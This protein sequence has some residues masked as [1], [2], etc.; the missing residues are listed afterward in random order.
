MED[1]VLGLNIVYEIQYTSNREALCVFSRLK[2]SSPKTIVTL[3]QLKLSQY[4]SSH[5]EYWVVVCFWWGEIFGGFI[6][7][8][9]ID[10]FI[11]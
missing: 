5:D 7:D 11:T 2:I 3:R 9:F 10:L 8:D 6:G 4:S 1:K